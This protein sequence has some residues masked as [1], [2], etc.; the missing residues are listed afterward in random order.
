MAFGAD[1]IA[2]FPTEDEAM[3][4]RTLDLIE[5]CGLSFLHVFPFRRG[6]KRPP[7]A[8]RGSPRVVVKARAAILRARGRAGA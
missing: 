1:L 2:G 8:C 4:A 5:D 7:R 6:R 3:A